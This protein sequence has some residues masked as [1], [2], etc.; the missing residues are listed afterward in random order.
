MNVC[1][2]RYSFEV[3]PYSHLVQKQN[4]GFKYENGLQISMVKDGREM[5]QISQKYNFDKT[6]PGKNCTLF[7]TRVMTDSKELIS[8]LYTADTEAQ[9]ERQRREYNLTTSSAQ[10]GKIVSAL[11]I[12]NMDKIDIFL[13]KVRDIV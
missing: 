9:D 3:T 11:T 8:V 12:S 13:V 6:S 4:Y 1:Q 5:L 2:T 7:M 10:F